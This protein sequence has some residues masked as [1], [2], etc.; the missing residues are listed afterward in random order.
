MNGQNPFA[1]LVAQLRVRQR[2]AT[3]QPTPP[4]Q[5]PT[6]KT[7]VMRDYLRTRGKATAADLAIEAN[8]E[9]TGL[10][11]ALLKTDI[12]KGAIERRGDHYHW[13][14]TFDHEQH[15]R[16]QAAIRTLKAAGYTVTRSNARTAEKGGAQ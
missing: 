10:V 6:S 7:G 3:S 14:D 12:A 9:S 15:R 2:R 1:Q 4:A 11:W 16:I 8:L 5:R 13:V